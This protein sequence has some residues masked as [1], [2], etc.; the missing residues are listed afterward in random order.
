MGIRPERIFE[1]LPNIRAGKILRTDADFHQVYKKRVDQLRN[2]SVNEV[3]LKE[4]FDQCVELTTDCHGIAKRLSA[5]FT[6]ITKVYPSTR[7][8]RFE[9]YLLRHDRTMDTLP[10]DVHDRTMDGLPEEVKKLLP[11]RTAELR[12]MRE[13]KAQVRDV[14][15]SL[16]TQ[17][18][19]DDEGA[20]AA[21]L[22]KWDYDANNV[23]KLLDILPVNTLLR[24]LE[25]YELHLSM[26]RSTIAL[27][28]MYRGLLYAGVMEIHGGKLKRRLVA[29]ELKSIAIGLVPY[30]SLSISF[31][32]LI[33]A[34][35]DYE[36]YSVGALRGAEMIAEYQSSYLAV[37]NA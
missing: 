16:I 3:T 28:L 30:L 11:T 12:R 15:R 14:V 2:F 5:Q 10:E 35:H 36:G 27:A 31:V 21:Q 9:L 32:R 20:V 1:N 25:S 4:K 26:L 13:H 37:L 17:M 19:E 8:E 18:P 29:D 34:M 23:D 6:E 7:M 22:K 33:Q 24:G